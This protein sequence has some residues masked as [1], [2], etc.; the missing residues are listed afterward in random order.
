MTKVLSTN[1]FWAHVNMEVMGEGRWGEG[2][3]FFEKYFFGCHKYL[4]PQDE[5]CSWPSLSIFLGSHRCCGPILTYKAITLPVTI[6]LFH[7]FYLAFAASKNLFIAANFEDHIIKFGRLHFYWTK[8][9]PAE[10]KCESLN[11]KMSTVEYKCEQLNIKI[12][13]RWI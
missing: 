6:P 2:I 1:K 10:H 3:S 4:S 9:S 8:M 7:M 5:C 11:I 13:I 12:S